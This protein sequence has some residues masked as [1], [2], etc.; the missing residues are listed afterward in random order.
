MAL[1]C[2]DAPKPYA[3][4]TGWCLR[5]N[6]G[7]Q[8]GLSAGGFFYFLH[9]VGTDSQNPATF[10][11]GLAMPEGSPSKYA[12]KFEFMPQPAQFTAPYPPYVDKD[13]SDG[14]YTVFY[15]DNGYNGSQ[16]ALKEKT[17][18]RLSFQIKGD[19]FS[20]F[21]VTLLGTQPILQKNGGRETYLWK[22]IGFEKDISV[23]SSWHQYE[24]PHSFQFDKDVAD[25]AKDKPGSFTLCFQFA[26]KGTFYLT[27]VS[28]KPVVK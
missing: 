21:T 7:V 16:F 28:L 11:Q 14:V 25:I 22:S 10:E 19:G 2:A 5:G 13:G 17:P 26:G 18:Y 27:D 3:I 1:T 6:W 23:G 20:R 8:T 4:P 24:L 15:T 12:V 9:T